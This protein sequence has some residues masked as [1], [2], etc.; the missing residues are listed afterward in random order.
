MH[1]MDR[2][3][4]RILPSYVYGIH[5]TYDH[6]LPPHPDMGYHGDLVHTCTMCTRPFPPLYKGLGTRIW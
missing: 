1:N 3:A 2:L 4:V 5:F 6:P